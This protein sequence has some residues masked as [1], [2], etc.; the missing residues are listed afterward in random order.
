MPLDVL[1]EIFSHLHPQDLLRVSWTTKAFRRVLTSTSSKTV[2]MN[3]LTSVEGLP[4]CPNDM[5]EVEYASLLFNPLCQCCYKSRAPLA[6]TICRRI[7][8]D[9]QEDET[10]Y[11]YDAWSLSPKRYDTTNPFSKTL[12]EIL[13]TH[14]VSV[15]SRYRR[16][17]D[18]TVF[19]RTDVK[20]FFGRVCVDGLSDGDI[21]AI[22]EEYVKRLTKRNEFAAAGEVWE[23]L[24][25][26]E[27]DEAKER[28]KSLRYEKVIE[29]VKEEGWAKE[30]E[31]HPSTY[32]ALKD[33]AG[34]RVAKP[35]TDRAWE[36]LRRSVFVWMSDK[37]TERIQREARETI[38]TR[39]K[40]LAE[41]IDAKKRQGEPSD[42][43]PSKEDICWI[44]DIRIIITEG[45]ADEFEGLKAGLADRLPTLAAEFKETRSAALLPLLPCENPSMEK[46]SLATTWFQCEHGWCPP[47]RHSGVLVHSCFKQPQ[48]NASE[49]D[50]YYMNLVGRP[51][52]LGQGT[53]FYEKKAERAKG[54]ILSVGGDLETMTHEEMD[55]H[56]HRFVRRHNTTLS[57]E[58]FYSMI[59][60]Q[61]EPNEMLNWRALKPD[62][63]P[64]YTLRLGNPT[65]SNWYCKRCWRA[66]TLSP[67]ESKDKQMGAIIQHI[68]TKHGIDQPTEE[69]YYFHWTDG[70]PH[71]VHLDGDHS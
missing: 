68:K 3:S 33:V 5:N 49:S 62:E 45:S 4:A 61:D 66:N 18:H 54:L 26:A 23:D 22:V 30:L 52:A 20:T 39:V 31:Q 12:S 43:H 40:E 35:L 10:V 11:I 63:M 15:R 57:F 36:G 59:R 29:K 7:C 19:L 28:L 46:L 8:K 17:W 65:F 42:F 56:G 47:L 27:K 41:I 37:K 51:W 44:P 55:N 58:S 1:Y 14:K 64:E 32:A 38:S 2:W 9:C 13:P 48:S 6:W 71:F 16:L 50:K 69:D 25:E 60:V 53:L 34:V 70:V 24:Q 67:Y 21:A